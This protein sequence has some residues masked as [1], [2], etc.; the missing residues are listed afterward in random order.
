LHPHCHHRPIGAGAGQELIGVVGEVGE[1][2]LEV[3]LAERP[4]RAA[5]P[6]MVVERPRSG[7]GHRVL[8]SGG[9]A[10]GPLSASSATLLVRSRLVALAGGLAVEGAASGALLG[11]DPLDGGPDPLP[12]GPLGSVVRFRAERPHRDR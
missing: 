12:V 1:D 7:T 4:H 10:G 9:L 6:V 5:G 3:G 11:L 8:L 2:G